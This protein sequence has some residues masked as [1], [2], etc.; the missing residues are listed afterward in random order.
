MRE[1][2]AEY[3]VESGRKQTKALCTSLFKVMR[4]K[5]EPANWGSG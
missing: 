3:K 2:L 1:L 5:L 4:D